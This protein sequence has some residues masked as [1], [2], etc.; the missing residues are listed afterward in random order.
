MDAIKCI[1]STHPLYLKIYIVQKIVFHCCSRHH[2]RLYMVQSHHTPTAIQRLNRVSSDRSF[3][4]NGVL[5]L[6]SIVVVDEGCAHATY[7]HLCCCNPRHSIA[8]ST[9]SSSSCAT[10][11]GLHLIF[12]PYRMGTQLPSYSRR[13]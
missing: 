4:Y 1:H 6:R 5:Y 2:D 9:Q 12:N 7:T 10:L 8:A 11:S 3:E 13:D